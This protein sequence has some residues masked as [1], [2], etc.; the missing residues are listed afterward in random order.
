MAEVVK[1]L[2]IWPNVV[3]LLG[4]VHFTFGEPI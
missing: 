2:V 3:P 4:S 1:A